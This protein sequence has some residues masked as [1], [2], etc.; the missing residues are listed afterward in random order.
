MTYFVCNNTG[1]RVDVPVIKIGAVYPDGAVWVS[2]GRKA[3]R[4]E[5]RRT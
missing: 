2:I 5:I 1:Y 3:G 4:S